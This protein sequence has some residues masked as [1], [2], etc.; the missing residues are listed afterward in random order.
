[1]SRLDARLTA[2]AFLAWATACS[3]PVTSAE[4]S[5][6]FLCSYAYGAELLTLS[7]DGTYVQQVSVDAPPWVASH[8][9][10]WTFDENEQELSL[11]DALLLDDNFGRL[12]R[13]FDE[14]ESGLWRLEVG[15]RGARVV[16]RWNPD[17]GH[18]C[19]QVR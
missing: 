18:E 8:K 12:R 4:M 9:G 15:R 2:A 5:G 10:T 14:P 6:R 16:L 19:A 3:G 17:L 11:V 13:E 1:M 7:S